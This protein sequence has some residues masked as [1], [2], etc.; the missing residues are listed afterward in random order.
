[1]KRMTR[2]EYKAT[3]KDFRL[4]VNGIPHVLELDRGTQ[5]TVLVPVQIIPESLRKEEK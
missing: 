4:E 5:A 3:Q 1:M 2:S